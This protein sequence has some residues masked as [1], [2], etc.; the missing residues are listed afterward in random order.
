MANPFSL[1]VR[2]ILPNPKHAMPMNQLVFGIMAA[3]FVSCLVIANLTGGLL[4][5]LPLPWGGSQLISGGYFDLP[6]HVFVDGY[7]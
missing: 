4:I 1:I 6:H 5:D 3:I 7:D 2:A